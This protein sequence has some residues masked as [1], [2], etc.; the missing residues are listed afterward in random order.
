M[1][2]YAPIF[3]A[4]E[5]AGLQH[6]FAEQEGPFARLSQL[7]AARQAYDYLRKLR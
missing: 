5:R 6:Y 4:A 2:D 7:D 1:I 3:A